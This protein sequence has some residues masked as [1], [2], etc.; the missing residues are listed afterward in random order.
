MKNLMLGL[1]ISGFSLSALAAAPQ[2]ECGDLEGHQEYNVFID[3]ENK[4]ATFE[5]KRFC[6]TNSW[7][8][9]KH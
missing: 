3:V 5:E 8:I 6:N 1:L 9:C 7:S 4:K 2:Y